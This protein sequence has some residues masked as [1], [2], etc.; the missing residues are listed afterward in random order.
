MTG[1]QSRGR[2]LAGGFGA[3]RGSFFKGSLFAPTGLR[4][5]GPGDELAPEIALK[6]AIGGT[7]GHR[8]AN[9]F[10]QGRFE[11]ENGTESTRRTSLQRG[12]DDRLFLR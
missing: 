10:L 2:T 12:G 6:Q 1:R 3:A 5:A 4:V 7:F 11:W 8:M 9:R